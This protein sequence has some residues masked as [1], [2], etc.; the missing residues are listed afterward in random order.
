M[1]HFINFTAFISFIFVHIVVFFIKNKKQFELYYSAISSNNL[2]IMEFITNF[3]LI[4]LNPCIRSFFLNYSKFMKYVY[5]HQ[6]ILTKTHLITKSRNFY[7]HF[8]GKMPYILLCIDS[9]Q[10][11]IFS[12]QTKFIE[13][14][15]AKLID[16]CTTIFVN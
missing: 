16:I 3:N 14:F 5:Y 12:S 9:S 4:T 10:N 2:E 8:I 11:S 1:I 6:F 15:S 7:S 13:K